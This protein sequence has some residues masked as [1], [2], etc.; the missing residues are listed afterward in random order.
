[1]KQYIADFENIIISDSDDEDAIQYFDDLSSISS[2]IDD[3]KLIEFES[4]ELFLTSFDSINN[5]EFV[6]IINLLVDKTL[7]H[8]LIS[9]NI[10]NAFIDESFDFFLSRSS[11][12]DTMIVN[13]KTY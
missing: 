12:Q 5:V 8:R 11:S 2:V 10:I 4:N 1:M 7:K 13:L 9:K 3:A 6:L